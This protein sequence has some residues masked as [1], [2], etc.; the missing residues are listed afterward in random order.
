MMQF[1]V[2]RIT[3]EIA[4]EYLSHN[5]INRNISD[6][7]VRAYAKDMEN[8]KWQ[9][10]GE[11]IT[12]NESGEL[13]NGQHR[14]TACIKCNHYF[15]AVVVRGISD[16]VSLYDRGRSRSVADAMVMEGL[17]KNIANTTTAGMANLNAYIMFGKN[18]LSDSDA[19][20]FITSNAKELEKIMQLKQK[21]HKTQIIKQSS[22]SSVYLLAALYA[23]KAGVSFETL[24]IFTDII[25]SGM[26]EGNHQKAAVIIR[27]DLISGA[28][29]IK[30]GSS[31]RKI[32]CYQFEKAISDFDKGIER[33]RSYGSIKDP[34]FSNLP[35]NT[36]QGG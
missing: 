12:F 3:P 26:Y 1:S 25:Q 2:E 32:A 16:S 8:G 27:N 36:N 17:S 11:S 13:T 33:K 6:G 4:K 18:V 28:V 14:L 35:C 31:E 24:K 29:S 22:N 9:L 5:I 15:D 21:S 19:K 20:E 23:Y 34:T 10:N 30:R 7:K